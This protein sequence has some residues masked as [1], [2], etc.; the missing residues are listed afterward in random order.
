MAQNEVMVHNT[1]TST[2]TSRIEGAGY[3]YSTV[4]ENIAEWYESAQA[5]FDGWMGDIPHR[6]NILNSS[7][8][9]VGFGMATDSAGRLYWCCDFGAPATGQLSESNGEAIAGNFPGGISKRWM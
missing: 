6:Q 4:G 7:Y 8:V 2:F 9:D 5:V 1:L 3:K